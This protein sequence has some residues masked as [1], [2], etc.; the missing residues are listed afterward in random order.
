MTVNDDGI[1]VSDVQIRTKLHANASQ[2][3]QR[4]CD[5]ATTVNKNKNPES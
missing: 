4:G 5:R 2:G 3:S 1:I